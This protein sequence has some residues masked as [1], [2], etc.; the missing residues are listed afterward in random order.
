MASFPK[1]IPKSC[2]AGELVEQLSAIRQGSKIISL[3]G[4]PA[5]TIS[6]VARLNDSA[7]HRG[8]VSFSRISGQKGT[9]EV[10]SSGAGVVFVPQ[11]IP[12]A[13]GRCFIQVEDP[14]SWY[15]DA[16]ALF[17]PPAESLGIDPTAKVGSQC[18]LGTGAEIGAYA[19]IGERVA[20]GNNTRVGSGVWIHAGTSIGDNCV[21]QS[22]TAIGSSGVAYRREADSHQ[23]LFP[24][25]GSVVIE[26]GVEIGANCCIVRGIMDDTVIASDTK[27]GNLVNIGH[28]CKIGESCWITAGAVISGNV[29]LGPRTMV[30]AGAAIKDF[31]DV[32]E[33]AQIGLGSAVTRN[34]RDNAF[35]FGCPAAPLPKSF[36]FQ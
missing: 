23:R 31:T 13:S 25:L 24:H 36:R 22:N 33:S 29:T 12:E 2:Q 7:S 14:R 27:I 17:F 10:L 1:P 3:T 32:G 28:N 11:E 4:D 21:I 30:A 19:V 9:E 15:L 18:E 26:D 8:C 35:V 34:V 6:H 5:L 20:I 16:L